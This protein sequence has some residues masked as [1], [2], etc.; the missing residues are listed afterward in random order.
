[1]QAP[2]LWFLR[3]RRGKAGQGGLGLAMLNYFSGLWGIGADS[4]CLVSGPG[5][6]RAGI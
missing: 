6:I 4:G 1:M 3:R 2:L 5:A